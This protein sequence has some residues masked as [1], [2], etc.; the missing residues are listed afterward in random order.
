MS[1]LPKKNNDDFSVNLLDEIIK[2]INEKKAENI[3]HIELYGKGY[4]I[5]RFMVFASCSSIKKLSSIA[6]YISL[7]LKHE[8]NMPSYIEGANNQSGWVVIDIGDIIIHLFLP[9]AREEI[10]LDKLWKTRLTSSQE[11]KS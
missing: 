7:Y 6:D 2:I 8:Y 9:E 5:T 1:A 10:S 4:D 3:E 11:N